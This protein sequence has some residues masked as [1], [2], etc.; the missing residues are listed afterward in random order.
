MHRTSVQC[1]RKSSWVK[2]DSKN[3]DAGKNLR[4]KEDR[5]NTKCCMFWILVSIVEKRK[6]S[7]MRIFSLIF[8]FYLME[9]VVFQ[10]LLQKYTCKEKWH[11]IQRE[12]QESA[13]A[14]PYSSPASPNSYASPSMFDLLNPLRRRGA[15]SYRVGDRGLLGL[16]NK[17]F[18]KL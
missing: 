3:R 11:L 4:W 18:Q 10:I 9:W 7:K 5:R 17:N 12:K 1:M 2:S 8:I 13:Y 16:D 14:S 6:G 15:N